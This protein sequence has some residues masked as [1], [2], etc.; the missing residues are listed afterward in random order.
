MENLDQKN[1]LTGSWTL[2]EYTSTDQDGVVTRPFGTNLHGLLVYTPEG[3]MS[4][5]IMKSI[6]PNFALNDL[7]SG[8]TEERAAATASYIAYAGRYTLA[9]EQVTHHVELSL[10]PNWVGDDQVRYWTV[11]G[12]YLT[13]R[14][15]PMRTGG[16]DHVGRLKWRRVGR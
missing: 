4:V 7:F 1:V 13:L 11:E 14:T 10:F 6:R 9:A 15:P 5:Q 3:Y 16:K 8:T 12:E 2:V